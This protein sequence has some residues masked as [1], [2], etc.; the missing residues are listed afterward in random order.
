MFD[1]TF[2]ADPVAIKAMKIIN[3]SLFSRQQSV[4]QLLGRI[5]WLA[6]AQDGTFNTAQQSLFE[7]EDLAAEALHHAEQ[8]LEMGVYADLPTAYQEIHDYLGYDDTKRRHSS[9]NYL[10]PCEFELCQH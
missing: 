4:P 7:I 3:E 10:T 8:R 6:A 2:C 5:R 1:F 9:L